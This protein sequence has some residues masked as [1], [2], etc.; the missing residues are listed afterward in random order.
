MNRVH[1]VIGP[2]GAGK[3]T[4]AIALSERQRALRLNLDEWMREL[5][6]A[7]RPATDLVPWYVERAARCV[8]Q[9]FHVTQ[10]ALATGIDVVL[11]VGLVQRAERLAFYERMDSAAIDYTVYV[12]DAPRALRRQRVE[13]RNQE[14]GQTFTIEVPP[15]VFEL[16]SDLWQ[17][18]SAEECEGRDVQYVSTA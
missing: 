7:D 3:S 13:Q 14:Q 16:A 9:I 12:L 2:V 17:A 5:F 1:L 4:F 15:E 18:P 8:S 6:R 10:A 11:E